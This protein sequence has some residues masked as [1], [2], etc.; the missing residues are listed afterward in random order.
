MNFFKRLFS[1]ASKAAKRSY[2][3]GAEVSRLVMDWVVSAISPDKELQNDLGK[4]RARARD[5][6]R[7][8]PHIRSYLQ[9]LAVNVIGAYGFK[10]QAQVRNNDGYLN[11]TINDKIETAWKLW[12]KSASVCGRFTLLQLQHQG[13]RSWKTDGEL[14]VY[15]VRGDFNKSQ[16]ALQFIDPDLIDH[17]YNRPR[18]VTS[19]TVQNEIRLGIE[20][21]EWYRPIAAYVMEKHPSEAD[22]ARQYKRIPFF[23]QA[24]NPQLLHI[25]DPDRINQTRGV[26]AFNAVMQALKQFDGYTE[27]ELVAARTAAAKMGFLRYTD[28]AYAD[29]SADVT[30]MHGISFEAAPGTIETLPPGLEFQSFDPQ[31][32]VSAFADFS[33]AV[34]RQVASGLNVSYNALTSDLENV[35]YSSMRSGLLM[36]RDTWRTI[37]QTWSDKFLQPVYEAWLKQ[38]MLA[39]AVQLD[40]RDPTRFMEVK[41]LPR[42]WAWVD[43]LKDINASILAI[44]N[45]LA[46]RQEVLA[47]TGQDYEETLEQLS[48][49]KRLEE[50]YGVTF[51]TSGNAQALAD[52]NA[53]QAAADAAANGNANTQDNT[54]NTDNTPSGTN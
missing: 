26:T 42:G 47:E 27:S 24:G 1:G 28:A 31:H 49:E 45:G 52:A 29:I 51:N 44:N 7:N 11:T 9:L 8:N 15:L 19:G 50:Q 41:W 21:D 16:F 35:N 10:L 13:L 37:Q 54:K 32:P 4:L 40:N 6:S 43:P 46:S 5:L 34:L 23:D 38:A 36:E 2:Y 48:E 53:A 17:T 20:V 30:N 12:G 33:K 25:Y 39:G 3:K 18:L 22:G 14:F